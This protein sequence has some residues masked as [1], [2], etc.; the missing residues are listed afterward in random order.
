MCKNVQVCKSVQM[1]QNVQVSKS[2]LIGWNSWTVEQWHR[3]CTAGNVEQLSSG[4]VY[5]CTWTFWHICKLFKLAQTFEHLHIQHF[6]SYLHTI[7]HTVKQIWLINEHFWRNIVYL[8]KIF[9]SQKHLCNC[10][11][12]YINNCLPRNLQISR[13]SNMYLKLENFRSVQKCVSVCESVLKCAQV[14]A[15]VRVRKSV[16]VYVI[17]CTFWHTCSL[18]CKLCHCSA[19]QLFQPFCT[20]AHFHIS[21]TH[22]SH[23]FV[24]TKCVQKWW[25][26][27]KWAKCEKVL[28]VQ[29]CK[30]V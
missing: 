15:S 22:F 25:S 30:S 14:C 13:A 12:L 9:F 19:V 18:S 3:L 5:S 1:C 4:T 26:V 23:T 8:S 21:C 10:Y 28:S 24:H 29:V 7:L 16:K 17:V 27:K 2:V 20:I 6:Y 11:V